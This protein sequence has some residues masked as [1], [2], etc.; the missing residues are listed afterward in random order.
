MELKRHE[1][2]PEFCDIS[3]TRGA[4]RKWIAPL[5][6]AHRICLSTS[7]ERALLAVREFFIPGEKTRLLYYNA[8]ETSVKAVTI[9]HSNYAI[10]PAQAIHIQLQS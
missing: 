8:E 2:G 6:L 9:I 10:L 1:I 7:S 3:T 5:D 4:I